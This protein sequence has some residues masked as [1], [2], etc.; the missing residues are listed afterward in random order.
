M[1]LPSGA[2]TDRKKIKAEEPD[3]NLEEVLSLKKMYDL[4][5][6]KIVTQTMIGLDGDITTRISKNFANNPINFINE[7]HQQ[8]ITLSVD[9]WTS[10]IDIFSNFISKLRR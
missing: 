6:E 5:N 4:G 8:A 9:Y 1:K 2:I 3:L 7:I 10:L